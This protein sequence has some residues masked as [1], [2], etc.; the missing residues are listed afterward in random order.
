MVT[1][2]YQIC[3]R[4][5]MDTSDPLIEFSAEGQCNLCTDFLQNRVGL[6]QRTSDDGDTIE[7]VMNAV[8]ARGRGRRY[9]CIIGVSG[10]VDSSYLCALAVEHDLR[11]L[12]VHL[13][14]GW[15]SLISVENIRNLLSSLHLDYESYVLP[16]KQFREV[17]VAFLKGSV[18][19]AETPTD[20]AITRATHHFA[21]KHRVPAIL[22][23]GNIAGEGILPV[24]WHYNARDTGYTYAILDAAGC[25]RR[26]FRSQRFSARDEIYCKFIRGIRTFYPLNHVR[27]DRE[28]ARNMLVQEHGWQYYGSKHGE[29]SYTKFI[30]SYYLYAKHGIDYRRATLSSEILIGAQTRSEALNLLET[31]PYEPAEVEEAKEYISKKLRLAHAEMEAI[32]AAPPKF[33]FDYPNSARALG[34]L[35]DGYRT[36][37]G[38]R[39]TSNF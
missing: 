27:Y 29:S 4:C 18:P 19:E 2:P 28:V 10:G 14:N 20:I 37:T 8:K 31:K 13:D 34:L 12:A 3:E 35:Y 24:S 21:L 30:Q 22:S 7:G 6:L 17:Q 15:D 32:M 23:G 25:P 1:R 11:V 39:K 5:V 9:D 33:F 38:K 36:L 16:W 26:Y